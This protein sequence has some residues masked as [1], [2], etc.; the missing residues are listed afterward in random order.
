MSTP[1]LI[2]NQPG[3]RARSV[4][5]ADG[6][7]VSVGRRPDNSICLEDANVSKYH[8][9]IEERGGEF[10]VSDLGSSNGTTV[11]GAKLSAPRKLRDQD[12]IGVGGSCTLEFH[13]AGAAAAASAGGSAPAFT[14][15]A[16]SSVS[17]PQAPAALASPV[18]S[19]TSAAQAAA[20]ALPQAPAAPAPRSWLPRVALFGGGAALLVTGGLL[21]TLWAVGAI[22]ASGAKKKPSELEASVAPTEAADDSSSADE[23]SADDAPLD[24]VSTEETAGAAAPSAAPASA[25]GANDATAALARTLAVQISQKSNYHF[26]PGFVALINSYVNEY[27]GAAGYYERAGK[28]RDLIDREFVNVQGIQPPLVAYVT[29][30][31]QTKF[32]ER[33]SGGGVWGLTPQVLKGYAVVTSAPTAAVDDPEVT[34]RVA[35]AYMKSL[36]DLFERDNFMYV[37]ACYG[38]TPDEAGKVRVALESKDPGGQGRLDFWKMKN[39]GVVQ[40]AQVERVARFFAAGIVA[41]NPRQF[42]LSEKP[43]STLY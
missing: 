19:A 6:G 21:A 38:M 16:A 39:E 42:G 34:T 36:L 31:S 25:A 22:G 37:V 14:M 5:L 24:T 35:A 7:A 3:Q 15:P 1:K 8:A 41:E 10:W 18:A 4:E 30:M 9:V 43:L 40:G 17:L 12:V 2:V 32:V 11:N 23:S 26:D 33:G 13:R 27:R 29:A 20:P 28:Y